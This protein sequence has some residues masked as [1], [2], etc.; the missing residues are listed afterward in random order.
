MDITEGSLLWE[1]SP[2]VKEQANLT[3][4]MAWLEEK[5]G[6]TFDT[7]HELWH[8]SVTE[9]EQFWET[10]WDYFE[11]KA[12][13]KY[14][15]VLVERKMPGAKWFVGAQL[16]YT[17]NIFRNMTNN[18]PA[19][20]YKGENES[21][22][23]M[24]WQELYDKTKVMA[25]ALKQMGVERGDRVVAYMPHI[26]ET[27]VGLLACASLGAIWS[28]CSPDFG[29]PSVLDRFSPPSAPRCRA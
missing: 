9:I 18:R 14:T 11:I 23:E 1:P 24:S 7:Y 5:Y 2:T 22:S 13:K 10:I 3:H 17:E 8:W 16:N 19:L 25:Q 20:L 26:P 6:L 12:S 15:T 28:S 21:L 4:Y 29:G 27:I